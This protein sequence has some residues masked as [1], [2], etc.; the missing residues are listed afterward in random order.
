MERTK[1]FVIFGVNAHDNP[2]EDL[3]RQDRM[4]DFLVEA[5]AR[6]D[7]GAEMYKGKIVPMFFME[8]PDVM[9]APEFK[10]LLTE[11]KQVRLI[12]VDHL[13]NVWVHFTINGIGAS[14]RLGTFVETTKEQAGK[15]EWVFYRHNEERYYKIDPDN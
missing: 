3:H 10:L 15:E 5:G 9:L 1:P 12:L 6:F 13:R 11:G 4:I 7:L 14:T 2:Y 8:T